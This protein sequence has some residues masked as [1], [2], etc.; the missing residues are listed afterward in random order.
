MH[1]S[2]YIYIYTERE[3]EKARKI[4]KC[5]MLVLRSYPQ[6]QGPFACFRNPLEARGRQGQLGGRRVEGAAEPFSL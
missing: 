2:I 3:R 4:T 6:G 1:L 5:L